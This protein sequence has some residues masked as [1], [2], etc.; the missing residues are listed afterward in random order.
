MVTAVPDEAG[1]D[2]G[3]RASIMACA[4]EHQQGIRTRRRG[5]R[6]GYE[7]NTLVTRADVKDMKA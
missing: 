6:G 3:T 2:Y 4:P 7:V 5:E 1:R